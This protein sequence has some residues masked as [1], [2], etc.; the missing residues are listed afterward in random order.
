M[1][2]SFRQKSGFLGWGGDKTDNIN[3]YD[4]KVFS[5]S[6][7]EL[8]TRTRTEHLSEQDRIRLQG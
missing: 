8:V 6:G 4:A 5:V 1:F 7:V 2:K 3:G